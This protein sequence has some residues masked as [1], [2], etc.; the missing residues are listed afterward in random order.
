[1]IFNENI[2]LIR[3]SNQGVRRFSW[4]TR[5]PS[6]CHHLVDNQGMKLFSLP[7]QK[8]NLIKINKYGVHFII[9]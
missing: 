6:V 1:M 4:L 9:I 7:P 3:K 2:K 8:G 5:N